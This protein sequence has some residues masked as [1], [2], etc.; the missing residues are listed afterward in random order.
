[1]APDREHLFFGDAFVLSCGKGPWVIIRY[2][3]SLFLHLDPII[4]LR[5]MS[6]TWLHN[7]YIYIYIYI[8]M[9]IC[10]YIYISLNRHPNPHIN[11]MR[12]NDRLREVGAVR[13][14]EL[15]KGKSEELFLVVLQG[16]T[17]K[18]SVQCP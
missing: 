17:S 9:Y 14:D 8:R 2:D 12:N 3:V 10:V 11:P 1:M 4:S 13:K 18:L 15:I 5:N 7:I 6:K 16:L